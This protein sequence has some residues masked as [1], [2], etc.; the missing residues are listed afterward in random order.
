PAFGKLGA[1]PPIPQH[2]PLEWTPR[3]R[4][5]NPDDPYGVS[6]TAMVPVRIRRRIH[7]L[8]LDHLDLASIDR[9]KMDDRVMRPRVR[10][11]LTRICRDLQRD[12]HESTDIEQLIE[13]LTDEALGLGPLEALLADE[14]VSEIM[15]V[16]PATVYIERK[17][18]IEHTALRFTDD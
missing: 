7:R 6:G 10:E 17:G 15:V 16:D 14:T 13:E 1:S 12:L 9:A 11:A 4:K 18:R 5:V 2:A 3:V 8:L